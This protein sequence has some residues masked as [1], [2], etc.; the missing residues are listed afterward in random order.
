MNINDYIVGIVAVAVYII[1]LVLHAIKFIPNKFLPLIAVVLGVAFNVWFSAKID[2]IVFV[3]GLAS[4]LSAVGIDNV[5]DFI[6]NA[7]KKDESSERD[8]E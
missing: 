5:I 3:G 1:C 4:G 8:D 2:F 7:S 6:K